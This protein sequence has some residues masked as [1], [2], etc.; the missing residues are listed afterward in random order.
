VIK[1][2]LGYL[3][4]GNKILLGLKKRGFGEGK[5]NGFGGKLEANESFEQAMLREAEE[6]LGII[7]EKYFEAAELMFY[8]CSS[9]EFFVKVFVVARWRGIPKESDEIKP[10]WFDI[11][12][13]PFNMMWEDD[14]HWLPLVLSGKRVEAS[15]WYKDLFGNN[16]KI[17]RHKV[18]I[19]N[20]P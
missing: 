3:V 15:F 5:L 9:L 18:E 11:G 19:C 8:D 7:P 16:P 20:I 14:E 17:L 6:E 4:D 1:A 12:E 13:L 2:V 10:H